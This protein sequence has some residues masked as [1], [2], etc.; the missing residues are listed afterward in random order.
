MHAAAVTL[1]CGGSSLLFRRVL[2]T[3]D[4]QVEQEHLFKGELPFQLKGRSMTK[5]LFSPATA[6]LD[7]LKWADEHQVTAPLYTK[8][9]R[10]LTVLPHRSTTQTT[11]P[12]RL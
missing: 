2:S 3:F 12:H 1:R 7:H 4:I 8:I 6:L 10:T 5:Y 9:F 11:Q